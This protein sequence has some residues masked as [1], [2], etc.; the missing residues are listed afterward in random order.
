MARFSGWRFKL[1]E[2]IGAPATREN[3]RALDAWQRAEGGSAS[4]NPLNTTQ[5]AA[6]ASAYNSVGVRNFRS[7]QQGLEATAD[8]LLNGRYGAIVNLLRSGRASA[9]QIG[10]A[11]ENSPWGTGGGVLRVLGEPG[12]APAAGPGPAPAG[13][14]PSADTGDSRR[15]F[16]LSLISSIGQHDTKSSIDALT[17]LR[18]QQAMSAFAP[19]AAPPSGAEPGPGPSHDAGAGDVG[20][21]ELIYDPMGQSIFDGTVK[22]GAYGGHSDH[23]HYANDN[24]AAVLAAIRRAQALRLRVGENP[25]TDRVDP[26]HTEGSWHYKTFRGRYGGRRLGEA[27]D[28]SG[29]PAALKKLYR[30]LAANYR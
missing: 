8:T 29:N 3:L 14:G 11:V 16:T 25:Y 19:G 30:W 6:G 1:L 4:F 15:D 7:P 2:R 24:P 18:R 12:G 26:V 9:G 17:K 10:Q 28:I 13:P 20:L 22:P 27:A 23:L 5:R 21:E